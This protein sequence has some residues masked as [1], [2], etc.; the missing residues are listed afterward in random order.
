M[1]MSMIPYQDPSDRCQRL[2]ADVLVSAG[3]SNNKRSR[4]LYTGLSSGDFSIELG[5]DG[6][7]ADNTDFYCA[8]LVKARLWKNKVLLKN[9]E[10]REWDIGKGFT[11]YPESVFDCILSV[12]TLHFLKEPEIP[13][14]EYFRVLKPSGGVILAEPRRTSKLYHVA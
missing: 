5:H 3:S 2:I 11:L 14:R 4:I 9:V 8:A 1:R 7:K 12:H 13:I 6:Y 10:F